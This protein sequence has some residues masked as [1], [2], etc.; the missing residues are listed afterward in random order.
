MA[1]VAR[2]KFDARTEM[3]LNED[4]SVVGTDE[5]CEGA[6]EINKNHRT[7]NTYFTRQVTLTPEVIPWKFKNGKQRVFLYD[8]AGERLP[9]N[10]IV[11]KITPVLESQECSESQDL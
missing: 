6:V 9:G 2:V 5:R 8:G 1:A 10:Y 7:V 11:E 3:L 4:G